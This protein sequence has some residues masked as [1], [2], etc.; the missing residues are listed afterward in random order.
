MSGCNEAV[1]RWLDERVARGGEIGLLTELID[2]DHV[3]HDLFGEHYRPEGMRISITEYR[4]AF[5]DLRVT[6][7]EVMA[8]GDRVA[9]R[10]T[11]AGT[12]AGPFMGLPPTGRSMVAAGIA[13]DRLAGGR[14]A[15]WRVCLDVAGLQ[16]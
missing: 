11:I 15:E 14:I 10:F 3:G 12:Y 16:R 7:Q 5:P 6:I 2:P 1:V 4:A 13:I 8:D 9:S